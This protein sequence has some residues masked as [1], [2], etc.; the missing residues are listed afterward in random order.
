MTVTTRRTRLLT[1]ARLGG[2]RPPGLPSHHA[3]PRATSARSRPG[4]REMPRPLLHGLVALGCCL[5]LAGLTP[6]PA[7]R[8]SFRPLCPASPR[9]HHMACFG[10]SPA[11]GF[12]APSLS[13]SERTATVSA[14]GG[15]GP[16]GATRPDAA[17]ATISRAPRMA[18]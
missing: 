15:N 8:T 5:T 13:R 10:G 9:P 3:P 7:P 6:P 11:A 17:G 12:P 4:A 14:P 2:G 1:P 16:G 18:P